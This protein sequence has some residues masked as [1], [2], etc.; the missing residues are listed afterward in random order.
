MSKTQDVAFRAAARR[1][2][3][4]AAVENGAR[5]RPSRGGRLG[6]WARRLLVPPVV[7]AALVGFASPA[8]ATV[9]GSSGATGYSAVG[10]GSCE[11]LPVW[12]SLRVNAAPPAIYARDYRAG[13]GND[14][15]YVRYSVALIDTDTGAVVQQTGFSSPTVAWDNTPAQ[16]SGQTSFQVGWRGN[17]R[18]MFTIE[19]LDTSARTIL[20]RAFQRVDSYRYYD[21][22]IGPIGYFASCYKAY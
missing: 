17:Y 21:S 22:R 5:T 20:G 19:W 15:Q 7:V 12:G 8:G 14:W 11:Y 2:G 16:I 9:V 18:V 3:G 4:Q 10:P 6:R 13:G 1:E